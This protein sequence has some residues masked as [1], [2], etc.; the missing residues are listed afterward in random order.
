MPLGEQGR[1]QANTG[2][3]PRAHVG[4]VLAMN[5]CTLGGIKQLKFIVSGFWSWKPEIKVAE[6]CCSF[7]RSGEDPLPSFCRL[8]VMLAFPG[9]ETRPPGLC[10]VFL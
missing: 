8:P 10:C 9:L 5:Y 4:M 3:K 7:Q 1:G 2:L 6:P